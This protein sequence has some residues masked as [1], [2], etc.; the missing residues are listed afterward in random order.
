MQFQYLGGGQDSG[1]S[2]VGQA[3]GQTYSPLEN[4]QKMSQE[5]VQQGLSNAGANYRAQLAESGE[6]SRYQ[7]KR[8]DEDKKAKEE[9]R[10]NKAQQKGYLSELLEEQDSIIRNAQESQDP[11]QL[12]RLPEVIKNKQRIER[13]L[14]G[15]LSYDTLAGMLARNA[16]RSSMEYESAGE[17]GAL[18]KEKQ[19][20]AKT[21]PAQSE[22]KQ[23]KKDDGKRPTASSRPPISLD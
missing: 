23:E 15:G 18:S 6:N 17:R 14:A 21:A 16:E 5:F 20:V 22:G 9:Q 8:Q 7:R 4:I 13:M 2:S 11:K 1:R 12:A 19:P 10:S 3:L